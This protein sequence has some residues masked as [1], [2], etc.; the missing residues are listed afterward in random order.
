[1]KGHSHIKFIMQII[2]RYISTPP[3]VFAMK[4]KKFLQENPPPSNYKVTLQWKEVAVP[5]TN[6]ARGAP[7]E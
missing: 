4:L 1:M 2:A 6:T 3:P 7:A 5:L